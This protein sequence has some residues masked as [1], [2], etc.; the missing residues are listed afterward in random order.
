[1]F[2]ASEECGSITGNLFHCLV[3]AVIR[4]FV[5]FG[6]RLATDLRCPQS[7]HHYLFFFESMCTPLQEFM[8]SSRKGDERNRQ[9][10]AVVSSGLFL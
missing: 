7:D 10:E 4:K 1:M 9:A 5:H 6:P 3:I 8:N 2:T